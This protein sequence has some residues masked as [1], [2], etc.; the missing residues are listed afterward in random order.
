METLGTRIRD[1]RKQLGLTQADL[2]ER[3]NTSQQ[4]IYKYERGQEPTAGV[5][6]KLAHELDTTSDWL[7]GITDIADKPLRGS[8][9]LSD[10]ELTLVE[11]YRLKTAD[12]RKTVLEVVKVM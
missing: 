5:I 9:D 8:G 3:L 12:I 4:Q 7:L 10:S 1:R 6:I 11:L 2:A